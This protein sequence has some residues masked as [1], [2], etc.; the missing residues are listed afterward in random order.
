MPDTVIDA[1]GSN[2]PAGYSATGFGFRRSVKPDVLLP[3]GREIYLRPATGEDQVILEPACVEAT[4]P[5]IR[6]AAPGLE[7]EIDGSVYT[8]GSSNAT[9]LA[10]RTIDQIYEALSRLTNRRGRVRVPG[11]PVSPGAGE[12]VVGTCGTVG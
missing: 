3:G 6:V 4:G 1:F 5:G 10:T 12:G 8:F 7:G 9:A 11:G 2:G